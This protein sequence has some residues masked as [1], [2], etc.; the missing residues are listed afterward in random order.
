MTYYAVCKI[1]H[2]LVIQTNV[3]YFCAKCNKT[4]N[5]DDVVVDDFPFIGDDFRDQS[6]FDYEDIQKMIFTI[7]YLVEINNRVSAELGTALMELHKLKA[8][9]NWYRRQTMI[10]IEGD[11]AT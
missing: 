10:A 7:D 1:C 11:N 4:I 6:Y 5:Q 3:N 9:I 8:R 2:S